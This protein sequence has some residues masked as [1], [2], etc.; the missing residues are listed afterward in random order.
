MSAGELYSLNRYIDNIND[1]THI[2]KFSTACN[3]YTQ[4]MLDVINELIKDVSTTTS[5]SAFIDSYDLVQDVASFKYEEMYYGIKPRTLSSYDS[6]VFITWNIERPFARVR[7]M[8]IH[9]GFKLQHHV[10]LSGLVLELT[11]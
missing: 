8:L 9:R 4:R 7:D 10:W 3:I 11:W 2:D 6:S 5:G 1:K